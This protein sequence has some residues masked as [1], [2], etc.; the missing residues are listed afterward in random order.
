M[1]YVADQNFAGMDLFPEDSASLVTRQACFYP[2][3]L[4]LVQDVDRSLSKKAD[5]IV[6]EPLLHRR[7]MRARLLAPLVLSLARDVGAGPC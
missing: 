5:N 2:S 7:C 4:L 6:T 3:Y 1:Q